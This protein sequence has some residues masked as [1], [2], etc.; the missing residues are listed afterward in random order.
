MQFISLTCH[1]F[2]FAEIDKKQ[3][4]FLIKINGEKI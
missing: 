3:K 1:L 4:Q 2:L